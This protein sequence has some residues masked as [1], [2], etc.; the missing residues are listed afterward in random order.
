MIKRIQTIR[1][2][3]NCLSLFDHFVGLALEGLRNFFVPSN[4]QS[5]SHTVTLIFNLSNASVA[6]I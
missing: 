5:L 1:W 6:L 4:L 2:Q 3:T